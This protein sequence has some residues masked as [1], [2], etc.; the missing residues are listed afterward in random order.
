M[1]HRAIT[2]LGLA[3]AS[4]ACGGTAVETGTPQPAPAPAAAVVPQSAEFIPVGAHL[5]VE[6]DET[7]TTDTETGSL[8]TATVKEPLVAQNGAVVVPEGTVLTGMV[9]GT[10][11]PDGLDEPGVIR[12]NFTRIALHGAAHPITGTII[13]VDV[14][15][16]D[17][18][19]EDVAAKAG[20]GAAAGMVL[21]A[22][23]GGDLRDALI[24]GALGAGAGTIV[25]LGFG[26]DAALPRG[27][28]LTLQTT[29]PVDLRHQ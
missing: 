22:I 18:N 10:E 5:E 9:T 3:L 13:D 27:T 8:F 11:D 28:D 19:W 2:A 12:L 21:G 29:T 15:L 20:V 6:L 7:L 17:R 26:D 16:E 4:G 25:S 24:G 14:D 1:I 23:I